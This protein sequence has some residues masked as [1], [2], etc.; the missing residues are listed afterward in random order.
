MCTYVYT[1]T[2]IYMCVCAYM[3]MYVCVYIYI[4]V[5]T[6]IYIYTY[7]YIHVYIYIHIYTHTYICVYMCMYV[8][9]Y[10]YICVYTHTQTQRLHLSSIYGYDLTTAAIV[11]HRRMRIYRLPMFDDEAGLLWVYPRD[12]KGEKIGHARQRTFRRGLLYWGG[13]QWAASVSN[14]LR[15]LNRLII[16]IV[17]RRD[18]GAGGVLSKSNDRHWLWTLHSKLATT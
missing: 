13:W 5:Y 14:S 8:Y 1:Y 3:C 11:K 15:S 6:H 12:C 2:Y 17:M 18:D 7:I 9:I 4:Y 10:I 16:S